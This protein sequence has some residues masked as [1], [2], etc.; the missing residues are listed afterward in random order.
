M[1][2]CCGQLRVV[3]FLWVSLQ[4]LKIPEVWALSSK[5]LLQTM[6]FHQ[7]QSQWTITS[8]FCSSTRLSWAWLRLRLWKSCRFG[9]ALVYISSTSPFFKCFHHFSPYR[10]ACSTMLNLRECRVKLKSLNLPMFPFNAS[11]GAI[12]FYWTLMSYV[13][14][15]CPFCNV[16]HGWLG[17]VLAWSCHLRRERPTSHCQGSVES[18]LV[19][20]NVEHD[21]SVY[22]LRRG[23]VAIHCNSLGS[24]RASS[25][26]KLQAYPE[27]LRIVCFHG[28]PGNERLPSNSPGRQGPPV[29]QRGCQ[30]LEPPL[31]A[32]FQARWPG[33]ALA[34]APCKH[35]CASCCKR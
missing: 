27:V 8:L 28:T 9:G 22:F 15:C 30:F 5:V 2:L 14:H 32:R 18:E 17:A 26:A 25:I 10:N 20:N 33:N 29:R 35:D 24:G 23:A 16:F 12:S 4:P 21:S 19:L 1:F 3:W 6:V 34:A 13:A 11:G 7:L 31:L